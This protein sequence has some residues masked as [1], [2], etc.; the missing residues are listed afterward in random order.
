[1]MCGAIP[2]PCETCGKFSRIKQLCECGEVDSDE[3]DS[4]V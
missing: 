3:K 2:I 4:R 1:M